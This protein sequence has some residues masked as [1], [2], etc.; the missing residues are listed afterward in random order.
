MDATG[1]EAAPPI[2]ASSLPPILASTIA[3]S[4]GVG[5]MVFL[6]FTLSRDGS[7]Q[8]I[9]AQGARG[10]AKPSVLQRTPGHIRYDAYDR[11]GRLTFSGTVPDPLHQRWE[12]PAEDDSD[13]IAVTI[14][15][16]SHAP[17]FLRIPGEA[18]AFSLVLRRPSSPQSN[19]TEFTW[20]AFAAFDLSPP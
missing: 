2:P 9:G 4:R 5:R 12:H 20:D 19:E 13:R 6:E 11:S 7:A 18:D 3:E 8:L 17:L 1:S 14:A 15:A 16:P 10:R